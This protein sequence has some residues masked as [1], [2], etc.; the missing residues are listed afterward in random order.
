MNVK[1]KD[2][3]ENIE[4]LRMAL[5]MCELRIDYTHADL[6]NRVSNKLENLKGDFSISDG[7]DI[8]SEWKEDW[9]KYFEKQSNDNVKK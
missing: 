8:F 9:Q 1:I 5:N 6:I 4:F 7:A 2:R 3:R